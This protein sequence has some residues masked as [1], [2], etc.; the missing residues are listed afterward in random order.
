MDPLFLTFNSVLV[1]IGVWIPGLCNFEIDGDAFTVFRDLISQINDSL[2]LQNADGI[3]IARIKVV[4]VEL[5][6]LYS[7]V[8]LG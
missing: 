6:V 3:T 2:M 8:K 4:A 7:F 1:E 5:L